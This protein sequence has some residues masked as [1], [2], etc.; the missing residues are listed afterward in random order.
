MLKKSIFYKIRRNVFQNLVL[1]CILLLIINIV[2]NSAILSDR[3]LFI[4]II[5]VLVFGIINIFD[6][7]ENETT[8]KVE[9]SNSN[10]SIFF[11]LISGYAIYHSLNK[12][13]IIN[14]LAAFLTTLIVFFLNSYL[15]KSKQVLIRKV[16]YSKFDDKLMRFRLLSAFLLLLL[17][18]LIIIFDNIF[19]GI[20]VFLSML[21]ILYLPGYIFMKILENYNSS[22]PNNT[23][24]FNLFQKTAMSMVLSVSIISLSLYFSKQ[25]G[26]TI[27]S[28]NVIIVIILINFILYLLLIISRKKN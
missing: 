4:L 2:F 18:L 16:K 9:S 13:N 24:V 26:M 10:F 20:F 3:N 21:F 15:G 28:L 5:L 6:H 11:S 23:S 8:L 27:K 17:S 12:F 1:I 19:Y 22:D 7:G 14:V 25:L